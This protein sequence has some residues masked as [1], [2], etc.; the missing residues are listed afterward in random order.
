M[1]KSRIDC[2]VHDNYELVILDL[3]MPQVLGIEVACFLRALEEERGL[4]K[5]HYVVVSSS[6]PKS[7]LDPVLFE[8]D[9]I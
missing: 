1:L 2:E 8:K 9:L 4:L 5:R 6:L 3:N 7:S